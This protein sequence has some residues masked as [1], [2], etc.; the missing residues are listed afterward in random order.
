MSTGFRVQAGDPELPLHVLPFSLKHSGPAPVSSFFLSTVHAVSTGDQRAS[1]RGRP[2]CGHVVPVPRG[3]VGVVLQQQQQ[4][5]GQQKQQQPLPF[6][7]VSSFRQITSWKW[8]ANTT[9]DQLSAAFSWP[10]I[11]AAIHS[12]PRPVD[13]RLPQPDK[14]LDP[15]RT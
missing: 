8:D 10:D 3:F 13:S 11:S 9:N 6:S 15:K 4:Q 12:I 1:F 2:L 7:S 5:Q 14:S